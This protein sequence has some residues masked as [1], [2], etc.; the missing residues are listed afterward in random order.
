MNIKIK[1]NTN[2]PRGCTRTSEWLEGT[3]EVRE[4]IVDRYEDTNVWYFVGTTRSLEHCWIYKSDCT[5][6]LPKKVIGGELL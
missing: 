4:A 2:H 3:F 6:I 1:V 5:I